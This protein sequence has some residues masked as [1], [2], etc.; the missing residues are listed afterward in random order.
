MFISEPREA[1]VL[2]VAATERQIAASNEL[3]AKIIADSIDLSC[4]EIRQQVKQQ[5]QAQDNPI[6]LYNRR[7]M[8]CFE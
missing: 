7:N 4:K 5:Y 6:V 8:F 2:N 3:F 1:M